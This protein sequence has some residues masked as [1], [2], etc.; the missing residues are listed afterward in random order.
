MPA[1]VKELKQAY[2]EN[3]LSK[4]QYIQELLC[5]F[6]DYAEVK[7]GFQISG[8]KA[9]LFLTKRK[10]LGSA[11]EKKDIQKQAEFPPNY[12]HCGMWGS[13]QAGIVEKLK[14]PERYSINPGFYEVIIQTLNKTK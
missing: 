13:V 12:S 6:Y 4:A 2:Q 9:L 8:I 5:K 1:Y 7:P 3:K 11:I 14:T 10:G